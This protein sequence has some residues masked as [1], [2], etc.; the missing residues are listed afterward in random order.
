MAAFVSNTAMAHHTNTG[1]GSD[2]VGTP[3]DPHKGVPNL[4]DILIAEMARVRDRVM[5]A[6]LKI[7]DAG[8]GA[9]LMMRAQLDAAARA[10]AEQDA[11]ACVRLLHSLRGFQV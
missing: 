11:T 5:P 8:R 4:V 10:L 3:V 1:D 2:L 9:L 7:G 6:Y